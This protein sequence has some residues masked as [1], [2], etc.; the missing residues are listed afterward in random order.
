MVS[1]KDPVELAA[2]KF[3]TQTDG[4][5]HSQEISG[6]NITPASGYN[7]QKAD[8]LKDHDPRGKI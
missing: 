5:P 2:Y 3:N 1:H 8:P 7:S 6:D 4:Q